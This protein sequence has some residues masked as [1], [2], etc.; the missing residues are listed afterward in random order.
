MSREAQTLATDIALRRF[1]HQLTAVATSRAALTALVGI[2]SSA[3]LA[4]LAL[5]Y[6]DRRTPPIVSV[7]T[8]L[9]LLGAGLIVA[10]VTLSLSRN[11]VRPPS[12]GEEAA[13]IGSVSSIDL[14]NNYLK[15]LEEVLT[16]NLKRLRHFDLA[17]ATT[18]LVLFGSNASMAVGLANGRLPDSSQSPSS[19]PAAGQP[20]LVQP[21]TQDPTISSS[22]VVTTLQSTPTVSVLP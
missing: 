10:L 6:R 3:A 22:T 18:F 15:A 17:V 16:S 1:D 8:G 5:S 21:N 4:V 13:L 9:A 20:S 19:Q 12:L 7:I 2:E 14:Q 11:F